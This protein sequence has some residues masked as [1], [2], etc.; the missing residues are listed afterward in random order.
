MIVL[1]QLLIWCSLIRIANDLIQLIWLHNFLYSFFYFHFFSLR[2]FHCKKKI[3]RLH[4]E[5]SP[6]KYIKKYHCIRPQP[7]MFFAL[8]VSMV[9]SS[10][11]CTCAELVSILNNDQSFIKY[12][13]VI[14]YTTC[15]VSVAQVRWIYN[16]FCGFLFWLS[17]F[18]SINDSASFV[19]W[20]PIKEGDKY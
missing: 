14:R 3:S 5:K 15:V 2:K 12:P 11:N 18:F 8:I 4:I 1:N 19:S 9:A 17:N 10:T 6:K 16:A 7:Y 20:L 13:V